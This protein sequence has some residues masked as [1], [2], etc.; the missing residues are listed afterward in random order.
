MRESVVVAQGSHKPQVAGSI[1]APAPSP[2]GEMVDAADLESAAL[3][4]VEVRIFSWALGSNNCDS[5]K[6]PCFL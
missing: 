1:P 4:S 6:R 2:S 3:K 5:I